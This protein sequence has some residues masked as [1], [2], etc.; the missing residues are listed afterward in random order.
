MDAVKDL[1]KSKKFWSA[2]IGAVVLGVTDHFGVNREVVFSIAGLFG[3]QIAG[4]GLADAGKEA[5]RV[6]AAIVSETADLAPADR[7]AKL[8]EEALGDE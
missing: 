1:M 8:R 5:A 4:Q 3:L 7:A 6:K 2:V